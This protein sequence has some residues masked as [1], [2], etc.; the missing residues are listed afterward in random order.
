MGSR[1]IEGYVE[2]E[3]QDIPSKVSE[4]IGKGYQ[5]LVTIT[6]LD[7]GENIGLIY[8]FSKPSG[9]TIHVKTSVKKYGSLPSI[10]DILPGAYIYEMEVHDM[11]GITFDNNQWMRYKLLLPDC[12]PLDEPPPLWKEADPDKIREKVY[13]AA[14][15]ACTLAEPISGTSMFS[16]ESIVVP[17]G[18]YHPALKEPEHFRLVVEGEKIVQAIPRIGFVHRGIEKAAER[19]S[20]LRDIFLLERI[21]GICSMHHSWTF[22]EAVEKLLGLEIDKRAV[23]I[24]TLVAELER[25]HSH[26][27]WLGLVGYWMGFETMFMWVWSI[28]EDI[29]DLLELI[30]GNRVHKSIVT[31]GGVRRDVSDE[32]LK[33]VKEKVAS[34]EKRFTEVMDDILTLDEFIARTSGIGKYSL[35]TARK[36]CVVGPPRRAIGDG[37]DIRRIEPY[38]AYEEVDY[39]VITDMGGDVYSL[40]KVRMLEILESARIIQQIIETMPSGN[41]IP[42]REFMGTVPKGEAYARTEAPRGELFYYVSAE[43]KHNPSRVKVRTPTL[44]NITLAAE[45]LKGQTLSDVPLVITM[46]DP[47][48]S[49][50]DRVLVIDR[51]GKNSRVLDERYFRKIRRKGEIR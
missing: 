13:E 3:A 31:I 30:A 37:Y 12:Y 4:I 43:N 26:S 32:K 18:P 47:C 27:L 5:H 14:S 34:F 51:S 10:I 6:G 40:I 42:K 25:I 39:S 49:C 33:R 41:P 17:F 35:D 36:L 24:R 16:P 45:A 2:V 15:A 38:G 22:V 1:K 7:E 48:F 28:R 46:I 29:M 50:M 19:R 11:F 21:C 23:Y 9:E 8:H 20:F 44:A